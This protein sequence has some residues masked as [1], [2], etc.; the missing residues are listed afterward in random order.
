MWRD[1]ARSIVRS[2]L[3]PGGGPQQSRERVSQSNAIALAILGLTGSTTSRGARK[4]DRRMPLLAN[5][6]RLSRSEA[7]DCASAS[8][9]PRLKAVLTGDLGSDMRAI[10]G[11]SPR[12]FA[13]ALALAEGRSLN[14]LAVEFGCSPH[15]VDSHIRRIF[16][17]VGVRS[18]AAIGGRLILA[19]RAV[20]DTGVP[21]DVDTRSSYG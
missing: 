3:S 21:A 15:T 12:E 20:F 19:Y 2:A 5:R 10:L 4:N 7:H 16:S 13:I 6:M 1:I 18:K 9:L 14:E 11:L 17:K 8:A